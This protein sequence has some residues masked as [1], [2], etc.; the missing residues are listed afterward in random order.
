MRRIPL[1]PLRIIVDTQEQMPWRFDGLTA[2]DARKRETKIE[3]Q[4]SKLATGDYAVAGLES[5]AAIERKSLSDLFGTLGGERD[6]FER[7][8][9]R[10]ANMQFAAVVIEGDWLDIAA[11]APRSRLL[12]KS[13]LGTIAAWSRRYPTVHWFP[14]PGRRI[15]ERWALRLLNFIWIEHSKESQHE[16]R[17][18]GGCASRDF[19]GD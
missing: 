11:G 7:E 18:L 10:L 6:R 15:A 5:I 16:C 1:E 17:Q 4:R 9:K 8:F 2:R 19:A 12:P 13:V 3:T 14:M